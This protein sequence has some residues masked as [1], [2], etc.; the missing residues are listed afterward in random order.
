[1][2]YR[3]RYPSR[4]LRRYVAKRKQRSFRKKYY[5]KKNKTYSSNSTGGAALRFKKRRFRPRTYL[6]TAY[7]ASEGQT[8]Y[9]SFATSTINTT[10]PT[11]LGTC[12]VE[13]IQ[14]IPDNFMFTTG[15]L[16]LGTGTVT[17]DDSWA[18]KLMV[19]GGTATI[20]FTNRLTNATNL[21]IKVWMCT[22]RNVDPARVIT[23]YT[24]TG[25][26]STFDPT[27]QFTWYQT[28]NAPFFTS[29]KILELGDSWT[30][31]QRIKP[32]MHAQ[33]QT[34][35]TGYLTK[36]PWWIWTIEPCQ[37]AAGATVDIVYGH[38]MS[39][40]GDLNGEAY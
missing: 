12:V 11:A 21:R 36:L 27:T 32:F 29:E 1:M 33:W 15:G 7:K 6:R 8:K 18:P 2:A 25:V 14:A 19:R 22:A 3:T 39:F 4:S 9:R 28:I 13:S 35:Q 10:V 16:V 34:Q 20:S 24:A 23:D 26:A 40:A 30:V 5:A 31:E 37:V 38:N 17:S